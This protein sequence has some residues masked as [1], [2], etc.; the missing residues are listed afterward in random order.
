MAHTAV[1]TRSGFHPVPPASVHGES[2]LLRKHVL[3]NVFVTKIQLQVAGGCR[4]RFREK[5]M[6][7]ARRPRLIKKENDCCLQSRLGAHICIRGRLGA[8]RGFCGP[9]ESRNAPSL[10]AASLQFHPFLIAHLQRKMQSKSWC[11]VL[12]RL[13]GVEARATRAQAKEK[14]K[15]RWHVRGPSHKYPLNGLKVAFYC[16]KI[17]CIKWTSFILSFS[18][19]EILS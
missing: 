9:Q 17:S 13:W 10:R 16:P 11:C 19:P 5:Q 2:F 1:G 18:M 8:R 14:H 6:N 12:E 4:G 3:R 15:P 7:E